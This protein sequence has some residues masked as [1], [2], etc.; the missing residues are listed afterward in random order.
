MDTVS[1][2]IRSKIMASVKPFGNKTT[3]VAMGR[4][5]WK[6]GLLGYRKHWPIA[7]KPDFAWP[8]LKTALFVD[9]CFWHGCPR[10]R[11]IPRSNTEFWNRRIE[12]NRRRD[13]R[14]NRVLRKEGWAVIRVRECSL[15]KE[16]TIRRIRAIVGARRNAITS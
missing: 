16:Q 6:N 3:E 10:C 13:R 2:E 9:G 14:V 7:G 5:L 12:G 4:L 11:R 1:G 15:S 8:R